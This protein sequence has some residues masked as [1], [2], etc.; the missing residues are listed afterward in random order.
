MSLAT[1]QSI[2]SELIARPI[3]CYRKVSSLPP[4]RQVDPRVRRSVDGVCAIYFA[5]R[6]GLLRH[7]HQVRPWVFRYHI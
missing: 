6:P 5:H 1:R 3:C 4:R 2:S 7:S